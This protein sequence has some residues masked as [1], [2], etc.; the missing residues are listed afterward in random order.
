MSPFI[1]PSG[2]KQRPGRSPPEANLVLIGLESVFHTRPRPVGASPLD[3]GLLLLEPARPE[4]RLAAGRYARPRAVCF[5]GLLIPAREARMRPLLIAVA[6]LVVSTSAL[7]AE[8]VP[9]E[10]MV[11]S[12][13][14]F[15]N[16]G[17]DVNNIKA[18]D[19]LTPRRQQELEA[20]TA[21]LARFRPTKVAIEGVSRNPNLTDAGYE[22][23]T[24]D[25]M[26]Y[27]RAAAARRK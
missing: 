22:K 19:V 8:P 4:A 9:I 3:E 6:A 25:P 26:P 1:I 10:V 16:P 7:A 5:H 21:E 20:L 17:K 24:P 11:L 15:D 2:L 12:T 14:H 18:D 23:F 27:L 13:Y